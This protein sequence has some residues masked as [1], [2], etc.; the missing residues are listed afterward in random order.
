VTYVAWN[1]GVSGLLQDTFPDLNDDDREFI[2]SGTTPEE[3]DAM[4]LKGS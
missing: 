2:L 1:D 3:W 4:F